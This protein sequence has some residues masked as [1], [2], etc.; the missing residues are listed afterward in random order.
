MSTRCVLAVPHGDGW[1]GRYS[2]CDGYPSAKVN[3]LF[4]LVA[5]DGVE[6]VVKTLTED[7]YG[8]SS[9]QPEHDGSPLNRNHGHDERFQAVK[10]YGIAYTTV[11][12]Q[13]S[14]DHW[15]TH[16]GDDN[17][18]EYAYVI[19]EK[20]LTV[21]DRDGDKWVRMG[22]CQWTA[23]PS[24]FVGLLEKEAEDDE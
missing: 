5:R 6:K 1:R 16:D 17:W 23:D 9:V 3:E 2:H 20:C 13:S 18:A 4:E 19:A 12:G 15:I 14:P 10:G 7:Y 22:H 11:Q 8:W 21:Y 24:A